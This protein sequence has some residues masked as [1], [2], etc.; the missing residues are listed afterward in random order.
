MFLKVRV[1]RGAEVGKIIVTTANMVYTI[2]SSNIQEEVFA[3]S[4]YLNK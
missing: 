1:E 3:Y 2:A 4:K